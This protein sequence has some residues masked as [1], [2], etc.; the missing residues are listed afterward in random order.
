M[1]VRRHARASRRRYRTRPYSR[2]RKRRQRNFKLF[3][4]RLRRTLTADWP[5]APVKPTNDPQT[6]TPLLWNFDHLSFKLTDFLQA[7]HGVGDFQHLPPFRY[8]KFKKVYI[9]AKWIN[10]PKTLMENVL[11]RTALDLD[12]EDQGRGNATRSHLDPGAT[13]GVTEPPKDPN[14]AP[15]IYDPL[16]DRA[17]SKSFNMATGFKRGLT[18][19]P[20]FTQ[21]IASPSATAPWLTRGQPWVSVIKGANMVWNGLSISLRQMKDMRPTTPETNTS[22]IPQVQYDI[23]AYIAFKEF[24]YETGRQL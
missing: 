5:T 13:P 14:K 23:S 21:E 2:Y 18:P 22:Q 24:D 15:F 3:H 4:L 17:T 20:M 16:Q 6:E 7:S 8:Y 9:R 19:K 12:G 1:R 11:G 10:W